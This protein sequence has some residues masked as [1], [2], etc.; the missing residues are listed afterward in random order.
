MEPSFRSLFIGLFMSSH[1]SDQMS[2]WPQVSSFWIYA[3]STAP[4]FRILARNAPSSR[5]VLLSYT[6]LVGRHTQTA[7]PIQLHV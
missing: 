6:T 2:Q 4:S 1:H 7:Q 3:S 5:L